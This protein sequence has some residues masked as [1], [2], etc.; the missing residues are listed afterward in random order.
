MIKISDEDIMSFV[1]ESLD[2]EVKERGLFKER[3]EQGSLDTGCEDVPKWPS[4]ELDKMVGKPS[5]QGSGARE[6]LQNIMITGDTVPERVSSLQASLSKAL[7]K[8]PKAD[9]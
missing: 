4:M 2:K 7:M 6:I 9:R 8:Q 5:P 3:E 1:K